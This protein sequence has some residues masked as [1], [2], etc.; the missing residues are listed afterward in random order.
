M[1]DHREREGA[2]ERKDRQ[3][4]RGVFKHK[5][6]KIVNTYAYVYVCI[7]SCMHVCLYVHTSGTKAINTH[8]DTH[9]HME[10]DD[11]PSAF[12]VPSGFRRI[13]SAFAR[14]PVTSFSHH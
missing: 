14:A 12:W 6:E 13:N 9:T 7:D 3:T 1:I 10:L 4:D 11:K 5:H 8:R 2:R